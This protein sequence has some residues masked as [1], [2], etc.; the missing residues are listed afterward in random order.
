MRILI[1][2]AYKIFNLEEIIA[3]AKLISITGASQVIIQGL[4]FVGGILVIRSLP[5]NEYALYTLANTMLGT[6]YILADGGITTGVL[7]QGGKVWQDKEQLGV[8]LATGLNL[9]MK[10]AVLSLLISMP[11][12][13]YLLHHHGANW[14]M[15]LIIAATLVPAFFTSLSGS[16]LVV[17]PRLLQ[18]I[19][20]LQKIQVGSNLGRLLLLALSLFTFPLAFVAILA[21]GLPQIWAN[22]KLRKLST[23]F[24]DSTQKPDA[25]VSRQILAMVKRL[26]PESIYYCISGQITIW[27]ISVL[28]ST[29]SVAQVG[30]LGRFAMI[31]TVINTLIS[32]LFLPRFARLPD[33]SRLL[34]KRYLQIQVIVIIVS[35][36]VICAVW[37]LSDK[38][39]LILGSKYTGLSNEVVLLTIGG[40]INFI[41]GSSFYMC[42]SRGWVINPIITIVISIASIGLGIVL[43]DISSLHGILIFNIL[44]GIPTLV[45]H[46]VYGVKRILSVE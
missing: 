27:L 26:L 29:T 35:V 22:I 44:V 43:L 11:V 36:A 17:T 42:T 30:A 19:I 15:T 46:I 32:A 21:A 14:T 9:R 28:G 38:L 25:D 8:V 3:W 10:L 20:P 12:L 5:T 13:L 24:A 39:L 41:S 1:R 45:M 2:R 16:M 37:L 4:S 40:G 18:Q 33:N 23:Q 31:F 6:M 34:L 7:A